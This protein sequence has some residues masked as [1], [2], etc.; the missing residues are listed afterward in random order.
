MY[1]IRAFISLIH[2]LRFMYNQH[3]KRKAHNSEVLHF[4]GNYNINQ[5]G[6]YL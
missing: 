6:R 4:K 3:A 2:L 1:L 5:I